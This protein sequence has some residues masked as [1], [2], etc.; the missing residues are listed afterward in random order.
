MK[1]IVTIIASVTLLSAI[2]ISCDRH[3]NDDSNEIATVDKIKI[4]SVQIN[5]T[6]MAVNSVQ[7]IRTYSNYTASN[8]GF[9]GYDYVK[10]NLTRSVTAYSYKTNTSS[11]AINQEYYNQF[12][13]QPTQSGTYTFKFWNGVDT[14]GN[15]IW[16]TKTITVN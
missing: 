12:N 3:H 5:S 14:S 1:K 11:T 8:Q 9:Y 2:F 13:F 15:S 7:S 10:D 16:I 6:S 4:D